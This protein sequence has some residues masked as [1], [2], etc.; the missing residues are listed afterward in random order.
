[1]K[2][3]MFQIYVKN[4]LEAVRFYQEAFGAA[5]A[6]DHKDATGSHYEHAELDICGQILAVSEGDRAVGGNMQF[7]LHF[8]KSD[9]DKVLSAYETLK[10]DAV[11]MNPPDSCDWS[12]CVFGGIDKY[13]INWCIFTD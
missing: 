1:M 5:L 6:A 13:G 2:R 10:Q 3:S 7:C 4:S 12:S 9:K 8:T 11:R